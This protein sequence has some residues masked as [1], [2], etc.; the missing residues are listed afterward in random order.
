VLT[1]SLER[2]DADLVASVVELAP[3]G[4]R[5]ELTAAG[6][7][8]ELRIAI[9]GRY[10]VSN[11]LAAVGAGLFL[12]LSSSAAAH[13]IERVKRVP[14]RFELYRGAGRTVLVDYAHTPD[15]FERV[16]SAARQLTTGKLI[17]IF[18]CGGE[19][20]REKRPVMGEI[21]G[22]LADEIYVTLDNARREPLDRIDEEI[23]AGLRKTSA[24]WRRHDDRAEA[25][26]LALEGSRAGDLVVLLGKGD[27]AYQEVDGV[28]HPYSDRETAL[29]E[30][31]R[32]ES[33]PEARHG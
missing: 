4:T 17:L 24:L 18:G 14:G 22:R 29:R 1:T 19:R 6:S 33:L 26:R 32:L 13:A 12:G 16:L 8:V 23:F 11:A 10:N 2:R 28:R 5:V 21:A 25:V 27:E 31:R 30:L 3:T 9:G 15:A 7:E 20:D